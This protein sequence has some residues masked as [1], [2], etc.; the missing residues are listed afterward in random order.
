MLSPRRVFV[1]AYAKINWTLDVLGKRSDGYHELNSVMQTIALG[2]TLCFTPDVSG[3]IAFTCD[4]PAL[5]TQDNLVV[6]AAHAAR[7]YAEPSALGVRIELRK[8]TPTQAGLGGGSSDAAATLVALNALW[9]LGLGTAELESIG[10]DLGSDIPFFIRG[11]TAVIAGRGERV[12][13][14]P[15]AEQLWLLVVK[16]PISVS[17]AAIFHALT[18]DDFG[19]HAHSDAVA[20][21]VRAGAPLPFDALHNDLEPSVLRRFPAVAAAY[22]ALRRAGAPVVRMSGSGSA[23]F[24]PFRDLAAAARVHKVVA[25]TGLSVWLTHTIP[26]HAAHGALGAVWPDARQG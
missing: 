6:R 26:A 7:H 23:L 24:A 5:G 11:G 19:H 14:L 16:P 2:D 22:D 20:E 18:P 15:D 21:A 8:Q 9:R 3:T 10:A 17:T 12:T 13:A 1:P 25:A 4:V